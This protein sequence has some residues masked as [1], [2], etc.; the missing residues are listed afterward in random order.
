M[1]VTKKRLKRAALENVI[2]C[3]DFGRKIT[4]SSKSAAGVRM[5]RSDEGKSFVDTPFNERLSQRTTRSA[6]SKVAFSKGKTEV[7]SY[8]NVCPC[9]TISPKAKSSRT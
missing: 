1:A 9:F 2:S 7:A 6:E 8:R 3:K 4:T 5:Q